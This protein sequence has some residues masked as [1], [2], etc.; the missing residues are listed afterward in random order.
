[1]KYQARANLW[2][3]SSTTR[4]PPPIWSMSWRHAWVGGRHVPRRLAPPRVA[5]DADRERLPDRALVDERLRLDD[6]RVEDEVLEHP[7]GAGAPRA[8]STIRSASATLVH[9]GFWTETALPAASA[10]RAASR[11]RWWGSR[12]STRS[13]V[14][15]AHQLAVVVGDERG[16]EAPRPRPAL[17]E[18][19]VPVAESDDLGVGVGEVLDR[20]QIGDAAGSDEADANSVQDSDLL[21]RP[22]G[23][24]GIAPVRRIRPATG[25]HENRFVD[26]RG[27]GA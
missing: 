16:V 11:W 19:R 10:A 26:G 9:I 18:R 3:P 13:T 14:S 24:A 21:E 17:R 8:A 22:H 1:M 23:R 6:G 20:V 4:G 12:T 15:S 25:R 27:S 2:W 7:E 5:L